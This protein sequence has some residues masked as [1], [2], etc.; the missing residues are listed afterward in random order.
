MSSI[1]KRVAPGAL[2][3]TRTATNGNLSGDNGASNKA[4]ATVSTYGR[5]LVR[6][7]EGVEGRQP[8]ASFR[9]AFAG[10]FV[11]TMLLYLRP[12]E[13]FPELFGSLPLVRVVAISTL[14]AY[15]GAKLTA[16][17][18]LTVWTLELKLILFIALLGVAFIPVAVAPQ[19][20]I[21]VLLNTFFKIIVIF[22]LMI[23][24]LDSLG[25]LR[26]LLNV[27]VICGAVLAGFALFSYLT[28]NFMVQGKVVTNRI[29]GLVQGMFGNP[30]DLALGLD[31]LLPL[32]LALALTSHGGRRVFYFACAALL[33]IGV[34]VTFSRGGFLG[35]VA[36]G[37]VLLWKLSRQH[38]A[39][40]L[41]GFLVATGFFLAAMPSGYSNRLTTIFSFEEDTTGSAQARRE[42]LERAA[43]VAANHLVIGVGMGNFHV[44]SIRE[45][46]AH[47]SYLEIS[48]ELGVAGLI[49]YLILIF[50]PLR[51]LRRIERETRDAQR[52]DHARAQRRG[53]ASAPQG[54]L[55]RSR[56]APGHQAYY[57]S[58]ALQAS[59]A[60][61][62]VCSMFGSV[63]YLWHIYYLVAYAVALRRI[64]AVEPE[65][66]TETERRD[67]VIEQ[68]VRGNVRGNIRNRRETGVLWKPHQ[69]S[70]GRV[71]DVR[72]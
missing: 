13:M 70:A 53:G 32:A 37:G 63:Q 31:L 19:D 40:T 44:Y 33:A 8:T 1:V 71:A 9:L 34:V 30:N 42:L 54:A 43:S 36:V 56:G 23:N 46:V 41:A 7:V 60:A 15:F 2:F 64:Y 29:A 10:L 18:R 24:L 11:F 66:A 58:V 20:S 50:A 12:Q 6:T 4:G 51:P 45:Q 49:A 52:G 38:R 21:D 35:L 65:V 26:S 3:L 61:Y 14:L 68:A 16:G 55:L 48:A 59:F 27:S 72:D 28:G 62:L 25:R 22:I 69:R 5:P 17:E 39:L 57:Y 67:A 47:N